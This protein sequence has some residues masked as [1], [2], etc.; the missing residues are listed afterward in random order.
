[1]EDSMKN[2]KLDK[3]IVARWMQNLSNQ[4]FVEF[5]YAQLAD[6][7]IY[8]AERRYLE[9]HLVLA[10]AKRVREADGSTEAWR[11]ELLCPTPNEHWTVDAPICQFGQHCTY[12]TVSVG[13][14]SQCPICGEAVSGS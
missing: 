3:A 7:S 10:N 1:M 14:Q 11:L 5:F 12:D 8:P 6:R 9:S 4:Q 13:K 2:P